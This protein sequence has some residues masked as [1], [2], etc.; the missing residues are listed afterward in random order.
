MELP[1]TLDKTYERILQEIPRSNKVHAHRLLQCITVAIRPLRVEELAE[2]LAVDFTVGGTPKLNEDLRWQDQEQA[3]LF[4]CSSL[5]AIV[6]DGDSRMVQFSHFSVKEFLTSDRLATSKLDGTRSHHIILEPAHTVMAQ[7]CLGVLLR[8]NYDIDEGS[9]TSFPLAGYAAQ[10]FGDHVEFGD[11]ISHLHT[12]IDL[13]LDAEIPHFGA[14]LWLR[15]GDTRG[16]HPERPRAV[17]LYYVAGF[18]LRGLVQRLFRKRP[19]DVCTRDDGTPLHAALRG[20]HG[21]VTL[22]LVGHCIDVDVRDFHNRTPLHLAADHGLLDVT[23]ML[24]ERNADINARDEDGQ[25]PLHGI[26]TRLTFQFGDRHSDTTRFLLEK[27]AEVDAQ[28]ENHATPLHVALND[29]N[30]RAVLLLLEHG[31]KVNVRNKWGQTPLHGAMQFLADGSGDDYFKSIQVVLEHGAEVDAQDD[32]N[33]T[34]L[35]VASY[36]GSAKAIQMLLAYGA[37]VNSRNNQGQTP[38]QLASAE[39]N[40]SIVQL[41]SQH[42]K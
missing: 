14:W 24:V 5:V 13:L 25:S 32:I 15:G 20:G 7:A 27:G 29:G 21:E 35:H 1:E 22:F 10:Y 6:E 2:V 23:R 36:Y 30:I 41:L 31:A 18:G 39:G 34:P 11:V 17:P 12:G 4:A 38:L 33:L 26:V 9:I 16:Q 37:K 28:D 8:L 42:E 40:Q 3:V 19:E